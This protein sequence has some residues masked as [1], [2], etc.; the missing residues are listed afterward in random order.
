[1]S[2][3]Q[4]VISIL[5]LLCINKNIFYSSLILVCFYSSLIL[6]CQNLGWFLMF[7]AYLAVLL[8]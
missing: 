7:T 8:S 1:M 4:R 5:F 3:G 2:P 6:V